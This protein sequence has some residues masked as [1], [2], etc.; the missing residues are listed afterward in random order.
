MNWSLLIVMLCLLRQVVKLVQL[1]H[2]GALHTHVLQVQLRRC[3]TSCQ[4][5]LTHRSAC[6]W[7]QCL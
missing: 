3:E 1:I 2:I 6:T 7:L 4:L 5:C